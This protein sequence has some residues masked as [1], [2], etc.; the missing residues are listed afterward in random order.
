MLCEYKKETSRTFLAVHDESLTETETFSMRMLCGGILP[1]MLRCHLKS[2]DGKNCMYY[3][4]TGLQSLRTTY[5]NGNLR[6]AEIRFILEECISIIEEMEDYLLIPD[7]LLL[8]PDHIFVSPERKKMYFCCFPGAFQDIRV[9][10]SGLAEFI[11]PLVDHNDRKGM[12]A[13]YGFYRSVMNDSVP[14]NE[15]R[16]AIYAPDRNSD[17][18]FCDK[19]VPEF[20]NTCRQEQEILWNEQFVREGYKTEDNAPTG[21]RT[22]QGLVRMLIYAGASAGIL[23]L[24]LFLRIAF[25]GKVQLDKMIAGAFVLAIAGVLIARCTKSI[26]GKKKTDSAEPVSF[27]G[28]LTNDV[29]MRADDELYTELSAFEGYKKGNE[30]Y[31]EAVYADAKAPKKTPELIPE[32]P[33][34]PNISLGEKLILIGSLPGAVDIVL[35]APAV[36]RIH[37]RIV[38]KGENYYI[39]DLHSKNGTMVNDRTVDNETEKLLENDD[40]VRFA[41]VSYTVSGLCPAGI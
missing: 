32:D 39:S 37:A 9:Q 41:D 29:P 10:L 33:S 16:E 36:S 3:D 20:D 13:G 28:R 24:G 2:V 4:V 27:S 12:S 26:Q 38:Q 18:L 31:T 7:Q 15:L 23:I 25:P 22:P 14:I 34:F 11:L 21:K 8:A 1:G 17:D 6:F 19:T 30:F 35:K 40:R 5:Q